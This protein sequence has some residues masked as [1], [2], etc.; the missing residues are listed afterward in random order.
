MGGWVGDLGEDEA[1]LWNDAAAIQITT[2]GLL[3][4]YYCE[5]GIGVLVTVSFEPAIQLI[6]AI[7]CTERM[8]P[9]P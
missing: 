6:S 3:Q 7:S 5:S 1:C 4:R 9:H 2:G 8:P